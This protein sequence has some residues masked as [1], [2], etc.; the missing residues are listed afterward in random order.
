MFEDLSPILSQSVSFF[1]FSYLLKQSLSYYHLNKKRFLLSSLEKRE[2][3]ERS[4][5]LLLKG[6]LQSTPQDVLGPFYVIGAP[7]RVKL[8]PISA[9][10][11]KIRISGILRDTNGQYLPYTVIDL[12]QANPENENYD[13]YF[14]KDQPKETVYHPRQDPAIIRGETGARSSP[15]FNFRVRLLTNHY[16]YYEIETVVPP[17]YF[18]PDDVCECKGSCLC[19]WRCPHIHAYVQPS[20][21]T[22]CEELI[23]QLYFAG[24]KYN[25]T[26]KHFNEL[27]C[28]KLEKRFEGDQVW[29]EGVFDLVVRRVD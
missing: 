9:K 10:G 26:D 20:P 23:T 6:K 29:E 27:T 15:D 24:E 22:G 2:S 17:P 12:W 4:H 5:L 16:G 21:S 14:L 11:R 7:F 8:S 13:I 3:F 1:V 25:D 28:M 19:A 18:D